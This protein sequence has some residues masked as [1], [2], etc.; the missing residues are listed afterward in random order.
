M[1][2]APPPAAGMHDGL[3]PPRELSEDELAANVILSLHRLTKGALPLDQALQV[4][5]QIPPRASCAL[6]TRQQP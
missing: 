6:R 1:T 3:P 5:T 4:A 2:T